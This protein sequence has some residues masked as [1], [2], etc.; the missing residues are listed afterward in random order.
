MATMTKTTHSVIRYD[1]REVADHTMDVADLAPALLALA[2]LMKMA[3]LYANGD[4]AGLRVKVNANLEQHCFELNIQLVMSIWE[5]AKLLLDDENVKSAKDIAEWVGIISS[6]GL[7]LFGLVR[8]LRGKKVQNVTVVRIDD[9]RNKVEIT[10]EGMSAPIVIEQ[11]VYELYANP[12]ARKKVVDVMRPLRLD[13]YETL[14]FFEGD[15]QVFRIT[16]DEV[17]E[18]DLS[19]LPEVIPQNVHISAIRAT[20]RIRK[21]AYEGGSKWTLM[22][23]RAIDAPID[24]AEWL[25]AFQTNRVEAPPGSSLDVE[26]KETYITNDLG[27]V[28]GDPSYRITKVYGVQPPPVQTRLEF[29]DER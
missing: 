4:R 15:E 27:E 1:G 28:V 7:S 23:K 2:D 9:G 20:V 13:G 25:A 5:Q 24:D 26:M 3:N 21:A 14:E 17:P 22:Y 6:S 29:R 19:D 16:E 18:S 12:E 11:H 8:L 10:V